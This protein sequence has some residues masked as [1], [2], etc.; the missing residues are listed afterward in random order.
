MELG[1]PLEA[2]KQI[3]KP[4]EPSTLLEGLKRA[5][6]PTTSV[7]TLDGLA[8]VGRKVGVPMGRLERVAKPLEPVI[9]L[10]RLKD[11][12][13]PLLK[14]K[15]LPKRIPARKGEEVKFV[16]ERLKQMD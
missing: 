3:A 16:L 12:A 1:I 6:K 2:L 14:P 9:S 13:R 15:A 5:A 4:V 7:I 8:Q 10:K 11:V